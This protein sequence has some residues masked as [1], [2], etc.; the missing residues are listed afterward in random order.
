[1]TPVDVVSKLL[2]NPVDIENVRSLT[3]PDVTLCLA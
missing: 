3:T 2:A 1:M